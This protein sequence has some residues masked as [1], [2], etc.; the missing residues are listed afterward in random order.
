MTSNADTS[1]LATALVLCGGRGQRLGGVDKG[2]HE[3]GGRALVEY[4]FERIAP[5]VAAI[6]VSA[7]R[8]RSRYGAYGYTVVADVGDDFKGPL[9][10][11]LAGL[12]ACRTPWLVSVPCDA[13]DAP[14]DLVARLVGAAV[15]D[16]AQ[17]ACAVDGERMQPTF[18]AYHASLAAPLAEYLNG[19]G[20][21]IDRFLFSRRIVEVS[22]AG[23]E[24][25]FANLNTDDDVRRFE[26]AVG[27]AGR[28]G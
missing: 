25:Q 10:G 22:F 24:S 15:D 6:V 27:V 28:A 13:P 26:A 12:G 4:V 21:K 11:V 19:G 16:G 5:Q 9:A 17:I 7:N 2:L 8:N 20:R 14:H 23:R 3:V 1:R 18:C